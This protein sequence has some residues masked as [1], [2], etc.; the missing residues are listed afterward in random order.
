MADPLAIFQARID[1]L[2]RARASQ[3]VVGYLGAL[4]TLRIL[5]EEEARQTAK[6]SAIPTYTKEELAHA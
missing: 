6:H 2:R 4:A 1:A 3:D 5:I